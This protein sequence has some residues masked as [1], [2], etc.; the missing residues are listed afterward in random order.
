MSARIFIADDNPETLKQLTQFFESKQ[1]DILSAHNGK[2]ALEILNINNAPHLLIIDSDMPDM[3][4]LEV[5]QR[6]REDTRL[7]NKPLIILKEAWVEEG[8]FRRLG[9]EEFQ[10]KPLDIPKLYQTSSILLKYGS[11][12]RIPGKTP[13]INKGMIAVIIIILVVL[14]LSVIL[15]GTENLKFWIK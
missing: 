9:V 13:G 14:L 7:K 12:S 5:C 11:R 10:S 8:P 3:D 6:L 1:Y 4:G 15:L 2:E